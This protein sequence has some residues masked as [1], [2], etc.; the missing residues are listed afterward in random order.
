MLIGE[1]ANRYT[2]GQKRQRFSEARGEA[3]EVAVVVELLMDLEL[4]PV[5]E[6]D[7]ALELADR[8]CAMLTKLISRF[9]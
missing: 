3:G 5:S 8:V 9:A 1:G 7:K 2:A 4:V 6:G